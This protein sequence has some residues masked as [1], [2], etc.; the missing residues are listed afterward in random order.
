MSSVPPRSPAPRAAGGS[1]ARALTIA[2]FVVAVLAVLFWPF[3]LGL[4]A[5]VLGVAAYALGDRPLAVYAI[6]VSVI[7]LFGGWLLAALITGTR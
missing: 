2:S 3:V 7:A 4:I 5:I 6:A 1:T